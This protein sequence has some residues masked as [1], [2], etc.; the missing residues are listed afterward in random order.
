MTATTAR[1]TASTTTAAAS[2]KAAPWAGGRW[3]VGHGGCGWSDKELWRGFEVEWVLSLWRLIVLREKRELKERQAS[4]RC[5]C[6]AAF[7]ATTATSKAAKH[8]STKVKIR[9]ARLQQGNQ[10]AKP[11]SDAA[12]GAVRRQGRG[13]CSAQSRPAEPRPSFPRRSRP[14]TSCIC[15]FA[16]FPPGLIRE[17]PGASPLHPEKQISN[18]NATRFAPPPPHPAASPWLHYAATALQRTRTRLTQLDCDFPA[19]W[20]CRG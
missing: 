15:C 16:A 19:R 6:C 5:R 10:P 1:S 3:C 12:T 20:A 4:R 11:G 9:R 7:K 18:P 8:Q 13:R 14:L 2:L 17:R